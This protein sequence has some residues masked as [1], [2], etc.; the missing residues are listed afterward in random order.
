[1]KILIT[2]ITG[3]VG[4]HLAE[5]ILGL[6][7]KHEVSGI[8]RWRSPRD[9]L[10]DI[11]NKV[12]LYEADLIDLSALI[13][14]VKEIKPDIIFHLA[15]QSYVLTSFN[16]PIHTLSTNIIGTANLLEAIRINEADPIVHICSSSEVYGQVTKEDVPIKESCPLR[17]ASPY[18]VSKVG[19]DMLALQ[20]WLS[21]K[22]R[23]I[24]TRMFTH[25]VSKWTPVILRDSKS[26]LIDIKYI[27]EM[28]S[29]F[30]KGGYLSGKMSE[31][32]TQIWDM[33]RSGLEVWNDN[34]W[35]KIKHLSCHPINNHKMLEIACRGAVVDVT[36]N[37]SIVNA[38]GKEVKA[39]RL[40]INDKLKLTSLPNVELTSMPSELAWLYGFFVAE[41]CVTRGHMR[42]DNKDMVKLK[43]A[44]KILLKRLA[45][46]SDIRNSGNGVFR[47]SLRK[48]FVMA[49]RFYYDC[50][51]SDKNKKI[52]NIIL[53]ADKK[54]KIAFLR[55][56]NAGDGDESHNVKSEFYRFKT[57]SPI[58][59]A[60]LC[61]LVEAAL[62]VKYRITVEHRGDDRYFEIRCLSQMNTKNGSWLL[63][64]DNSIIKITSLKYSQEVWDFETENHWFH[65]GI[66]GNILHNTGPRR[67]DTFAMSFFAK[68]TAAGELGLS[69]PVIRVGNL[70]SVRTFCDVRDAVKAYWIMVNKCR[71]GEVYN[72]GGNR[73][74]TIGEALDILL[75]FSSQKFEIKVDPEL[76]RP[77]DVTLQIPCIDKF[78]N[79]TGWQPQIPLEKT[80][81]DLLD[82]WRKELK[83]SPWKV[84]TVIK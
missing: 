28:R 67:G 24:R 39:G 33:S 43:K 36:D 65:A 60:S 55:G 2:G 74:T 61:Y 70:K 57:K 11:Y 81:E 44:K 62:N 4:S 54:T 63:K 41:G 68:Q 37:H 51:A 29:A 9:N 45:V 6:K 32:G 25:S 5:Y 38:A 13:R 40:T 17:P 27:S 83:R 84:V 7:E 80:L 20:Y 30:K 16:S 59:A 76:L 64:D 3:F 10:S 22:I 78:K 72:I 8:C 34:R 21:H 23:T 48:P 26:G 79:E 69:E 58:L 19:E 73:T 12:K 71:P 15:A 42:I 82:Y 35:T 31:D 53:N 46:N 56:Y 1:M 66:G 47:L 14:V 75:S 52:P 77:S 50:Y 49:R 18:A